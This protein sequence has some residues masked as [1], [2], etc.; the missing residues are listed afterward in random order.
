M[1]SKGKESYE[2]QRKR[3][4]FEETTTKNFQ[5][6]AGV[7]VLLASCNENSR[8]IFLAEIKVLSQKTL[9]YKLY[10][11]TVYVLRNPEDFKQKKTTLKKI[12]G[13]KVTR[14][15]NCSSK[16]KHKKQLKTSKMCSQAE[17]T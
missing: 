12:Y 13:I 11:K 10:S 17:K 2:V 1:D 6:I 14:I 5:I 8:T 3:K 7:D 4:F 15:T 9:S 16:G